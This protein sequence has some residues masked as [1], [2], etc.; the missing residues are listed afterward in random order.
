M[1]DTGNSTIRKVTPAG[2]VT[3]LAGL[4]GAPGSADGT[5]SAA[6]FRHPRG[7]SVDS[8]GNIYVA[9]TDNHTLREVTPAGIVT[10]IGGLALNPGS[11]NG[12]RTAARFNNPW[13]VTVDAAGGI[14]VADT[15]NENDPQRHPRTCPACDHLCSSNK[16]VACGSAWSF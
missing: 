16:T 2:V 9:D 7:V 14:Y 11:A 6:S 5:G 4:A 3:T 10:T 13:S 8:L 12:F 15:A 1:A